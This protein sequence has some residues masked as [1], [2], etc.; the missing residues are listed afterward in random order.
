[1]NKIILT[2]Y[3]SIIQ[4]MAEK[5]MTIENRDERTAYAN[6]VVKLMCS[7]NP[8]VKQMPDYQSKVW[9]QL[10]YM[11]DYKLDIDWPVKVIRPEDKLPLQRIP[12]DVHQIR[13]RQYGNLVEQMLLQASKIENEEERNLAVAQISDRMRKIMKIKKGNNNDCRIESDIQQYMDAFSS[14]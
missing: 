11:T 1:M 10:A 3:G 5:A 14:K 6:A 7:L 9:N 4:K 2:E 12:Y 8:K 13:F